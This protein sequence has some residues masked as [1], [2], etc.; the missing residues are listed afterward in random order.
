MPSALAR[1][2]HVAHGGW[3]RG[4]L[5]LALLYMYRNGFAQ[6]RLDGRGIALSLKFDTSPWADSQLAV[7]E[8]F[9]GLL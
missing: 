9:R 5:A 2:R 8:P 1:L 3:A 6:I 7:R 4:G